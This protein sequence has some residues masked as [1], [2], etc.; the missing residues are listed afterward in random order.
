MIQFGG[1]QILTEIVR[2]QKAGDPVGLTSICSANRFVVEAGLRQAAIHKTPILIEATCNQVNQFGGYS[3]KT[4]EQFAASVA[5]LV[6]ET[7]CPAAWVL[8]GGDHLGPFPWR[9][10]PAA[11]AMIK[12]ADMVRAYVRAGF[13]KIHLDASMACADDDPGQSIPADAVAERAAMLCEAAENSRGSVLDLPEPVYVIGTEVPAPGG[14]ADDKSPPRTTDPHD[15]AANIET[16]RAAFERQG[17][18]DAWERV[19]AVVVQP[20]VEFGDRHVFEY[21]PIAAAPLAGFIRGNP[22][23]VYEAHSTDFQ[24]VRALEAMVADQFAILKVGPALT[25]AFREAVFS[26]G[27]MEEEWLG[28]RR[29]IQLSGL[30]KTIDLAMINSPRYWREYYRGSP[31]E[32]AFARVFSRLDRVRYYWDVPD[33]QQALNRLFANLEQYPAP[34]TLLSQHLPTQHRRVRDG[35]IPNQP[36][37]LAVDHIMEV[38][39]GYREACGASPTS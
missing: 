11:A 18:T 12:A 9:D 7:H 15:V 36:R 30:A 13:A 35:S 20:G 25:F 26:L 37:A 24:P 8:L 34:Q 33:V 32:I 17:L 27:R 14:T 10:E 6:D 29:G 2:R 1:T 23:L 28:R 4:P 38:L 3:G 5:G 39:D 31:D 19:Q 16:F 22:S 21:D